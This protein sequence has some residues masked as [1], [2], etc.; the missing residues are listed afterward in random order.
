VVFLISMHDDVILNLSLAKTG[1]DG[2]G[3]GLGWGVG[4]SSCDRQG[5]LSIYSTSG[6]ITNH[7]T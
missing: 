5:H 2:M 6:H 3:V 7:G 1:G 4:M